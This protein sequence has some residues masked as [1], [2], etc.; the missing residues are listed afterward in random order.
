MT[1]EWLNSS[2]REVLMEPSPTASDASAANQ[3]KK[4][5]PGALSIGFSA[6]FFWFLLMA[7][8]QGGWAATW[9]G[10]VGVML[11]AALGGTLAGMSHLFTR[12]P[13][14]VVT[15]VLMYASLAWAYLAGT[16]TSWR[17]VGWDA[18]GVLIGVV[19]VAVLVDPVVPDLRCVGVD[20]AVLVVAVEVTLVA[21][22]G[23][24]LEAIAVH[25]VA[26]VGD[27]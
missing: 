23:A 16:F 5:L 24:G 3:T 18:L 11:L 12:R 14:E 13:L 10:F 27:R 19:A 4:R 25:V 8:D 17:Q 9:K 1:T 21:V 6:A 2:Q 7:F 20:G 15:I 26:A 22:L